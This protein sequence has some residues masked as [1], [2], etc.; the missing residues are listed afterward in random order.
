MLI[1]RNKMWLYLK[2]PYVLLKEVPFVAD[3]ENFQVSLLIKK[4]RDV[5]YASVMNTALY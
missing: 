3:E 4:G 1:F 2:F 5:N